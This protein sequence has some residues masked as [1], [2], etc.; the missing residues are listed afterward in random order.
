MPAL[1]TRLLACALDPTTDPASL[2][3]CDGGPAVV[4]DIDETLTTLDS[5]WLDQLVDPTH[6]PAM[7]PDA[8]TLMNGLHDLG[9]PIVY[10]TARGDDPVLGDDRTATEATED[11]LEQHDFPPGELYLSDG[12]GLIGDP[13]AE[14]K[15]EVLAALS[16][17]GFVFDLA[18]GNAES[19]VDAYR[20]SG[21]SDASIRLVGQLAGTMDVP[22]IPDDEAFTSYA[23]TVLPTLE[24][25]DACR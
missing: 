16:D 15:T 2:G 5:E 14:F 1:L 12:I 6:D 23:A 4:T 17:R 9:Y 3:S 13:A 25:V 20:A 7:R 18:Y 21:I 8:N 22:G 10:L 19:D 11:W 24:P